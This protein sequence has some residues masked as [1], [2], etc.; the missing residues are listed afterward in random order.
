MLI[1]T[2]DDNVL[3]VP[4]TLLAE[5]ST[6]YGEECSRG[7]DPDPHLLRD[8][9]RIGNVGGFVYYSKTGEH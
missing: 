2:E 5:V 6:P 3:L 7:R 4:F 1:Q 8:V 9:S